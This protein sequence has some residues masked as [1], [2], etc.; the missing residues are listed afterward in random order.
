M[1]PL[2]HHDTRAEDL[3]CNNRAER[4]WYMRVRLDHL[5]RGSLCSTEAI[6]I[7]VINFSQGMIIDV[8]GREVQ[9][10]SYRQ[11]TVNGLSEL[12]LRLYDIAE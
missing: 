7:S 5:F 9:A 1:N 8:L 3:A 11:L 6:S 12:V 4:S 2:R 10:P